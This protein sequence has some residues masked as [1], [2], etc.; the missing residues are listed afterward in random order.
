MNSTD[1]PTQRENE[2]P[3][4]NVNI[5]DTEAASAEQEER[6]RR[7]KLAL[8]DNRGLLGRVE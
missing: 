1:N 5:E 4:E 7:E 6:L 8:L 3:E 2:N